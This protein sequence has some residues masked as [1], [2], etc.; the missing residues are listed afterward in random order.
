MHWVLSG[1]HV[2]CQSYP[3][4]TLKIFTNFK[5]IPGSQSRIA[6]SSHILNSFLSIQEHWVCFSIFSSPTLPS[7]FKESLTDMLL[8]LLLLFFLPTTLNL[9]IQI[10]SGSHFLRKQP[11]L[12]NPVTKQQDTKAVQQVQLSIKKKKLIPHQ[13]VIIYTLFYIVEKTLYKQSQFLFNWKLPG[14][15]AKKS[16]DQLLRLQPS[17][18]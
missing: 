2:L 11:Q 3:M 13:L 14:R 4:R 12:L 16:V 8:D 7:C 9:S 1:C 17:I 5:R 15:M 6:E 10:Y 18:T